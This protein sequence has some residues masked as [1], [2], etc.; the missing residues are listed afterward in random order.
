MG[1]VAGLDLR[2]IDQL[3]VGLVDQRRGVEDGT[4]LVPR[5]LVMRDAAQVVVDQRHEALESVWIAPTVR[6]E[7]IGEVRIGHPRIL[8]Q[9]AGMGL[10]R[11]WGSG[12]GQPTVGT[13][14]R[15]LHPPTVLND[16]EWPMGSAEAL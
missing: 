12:G 16:R 14:G 3:Q 6:D 11:T 8:V 7:Q 13:F 15:Y 10:D 9:L 2:L 5:Q 1:A 4:A